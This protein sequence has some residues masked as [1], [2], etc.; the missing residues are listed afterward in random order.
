MVGGP[1]SG[2]PVWE[3]AYRPHGEGV[4]AQATTNHYKFT[5][6][7]PNSESN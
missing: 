1:D 6:K 3:T 7:E 5:D 2:A 4:N